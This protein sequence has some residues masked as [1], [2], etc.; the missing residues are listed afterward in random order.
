[1][2]ANFSSPNCIRTNMNL[3]RNFKRKNSIFCHRKKRSKLGRKSSFR[4][5]FRVSI[6]ISVW[7]QW[8]HGD[9]EVD[10]HF[11][12][13][14][15]T[16]NLVNEAYKFYSLSFFRS[17][18]VT[19]I[20]R[21]YSFFAVH[22]FVRS[23]FVVYR[24]DCSLRRNSLATSRIFSHE[25]LH[26][27]TR[28]IPF[29]KSIENIDRDVMSVCYLGGRHRKMLRGFLPRS[30]CFMSTEALRQRFRKMPVC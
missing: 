30:I 13:D 6:I 4:V 22:L 3:I 15:D 23:S 8:V 5:N 9:D 16:Q 2:M 11:A 27:H 26:T 24:F 7:K 10:V 17:S 14:T 19:W 1:M 25:R 18:A 29:D 21:S 12:N 28:R 20:Y